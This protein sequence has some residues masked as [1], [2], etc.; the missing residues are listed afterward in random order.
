[1]N[2]KKLSIYLETSFISY[3]T[4][5]TNSDPFINANQRLTKE[6]WHIKR[7]LHT[8]F[9]SQTVLD[10]IASGHE[11]AGN[12]RIESI[13]EAQIL[14]ITSEVLALAKAFIDKKI[15]P[16]KASEDAFHL[17]VSTINEIDILLTWNC[18]H[19]ANREIENK[20]RETCEKLG[21][22][23]PSIKTPANLLGA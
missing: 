13:K 23:L 16:I 4:N 18:K 22:T 9:I 8:L 12:R 17:S 20:L 11:E 2:E 5:K 19:I 3:L 10:E 1:M 7:H 14:S 15:I 6:W 21:Y